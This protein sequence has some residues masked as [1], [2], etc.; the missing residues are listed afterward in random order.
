M[1]ISPEQLKDAVEMELKNTILK[2]LKNKKCSWWSRKRNKKI[3]DDHITFKDVTGNY[4]KSL[5]LKKT[6]EDDYTKNITWYASGK[7]YRLTHLLEKG[8]ATRNGGRTRA[9]PHIKYGDEY[10]KSELPKRI[11]EAIRND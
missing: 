11:K 6:Y 8:H 9:F 2:L 7:E 1:N 5:K 3:I 10:A 4:R